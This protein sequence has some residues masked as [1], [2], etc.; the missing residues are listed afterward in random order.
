MVN[1]WFY[2]SKSDATEASYT[3]IKKHFGCFFE[4]A[5][6]SETKNTYIFNVTF[7]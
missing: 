6:V 2:S 4:V 7:L 1:K 3:S 5:A